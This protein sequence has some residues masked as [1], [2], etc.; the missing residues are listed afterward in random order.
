MKR[1]FKIDYGSKGTRLIWTINNGHFVCFDNTPFCVVNK[2]ILDCQFGYYYKAEVFTSTFTGYS[3]VLH[4]LTY[5]N[6]LIT[7]CC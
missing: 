4:I 1:Y 2:K 6:I 7:K 5:L 3:V